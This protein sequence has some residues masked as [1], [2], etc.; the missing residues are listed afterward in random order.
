MGKSWST[1][2]EDLS[3]GDPF[4]AGDK[5]IKNSSDTRAALDDLYILKLRKKKNKNQESTTLIALKFIRLGQ[6][7]GPRSLN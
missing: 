4:P 6:K 5:L 1:T 7:V 3:D 2:E